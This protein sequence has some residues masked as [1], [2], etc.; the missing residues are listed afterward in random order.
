MIKIGIFAMQRPQAID[1]DIESIKKYTVNDYE[2]MIACDSQMMYDYCI[3]KGY[4]C[5]GGGERVGYAKNRNRL[6]KWFLDNPA[7][8]LFLFD[9][10][11]Y[12]IKKGWDQWI[13]DAHKDTGYPYLTFSPNCGMYGKIRGEIH[14]KKYIGKLT[15]LDGTMMLSMQPIVLEKLG[16]INTVF[17]MYGGE[18]S[19]FGQRAKREGMIP[20]RGTS[21][22]GMDEYLWSPHIDEY[23]KLGPRGALTDW[24]TKQ[25]EADYALSIFP[26]VAN[27]SP[28]YQRIIT[29]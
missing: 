13:L 5:V 28:I 26:K 25:E 17:G 11:C 18:T 7:D 12:P 6:H 19:E 23:L 9:D 29:E 10:D 1:F 21:V 27:S 3:E 15:E 16:G 20:M 14:F 4:P 2:L 8:H 22:F 24:P